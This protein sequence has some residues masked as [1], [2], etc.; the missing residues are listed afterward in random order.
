[1]AQDRFGRDISY[2]R[3]SLTDKC[4]L[5]CV[6]CMPEDMTFR[7]RQEL[8][9]D[10]EILRLVGVF[11]DLGFHKFRLTGGEPTVRADLVGLVRGIAQTPGVDTVAMT[12]NG[13]LLEQMAQPLAE[14]GLQR[15]N[16][17]IDTL[18]PRK[19]RQV[20]RWGDVQDV[21]AGI[22]AAERVGL[23]VKLNAVVVRGYNDREDVV[24]LARLTLFKPWQVRFI[25]M[26]PFG[27]VADFQQAGVVPEEELR[28]TIVA[29]LGPLT[30]VNAG[31]LD[32]EAR[33]Y[34]LAEGL[35]TLG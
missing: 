14:A 34:R 17:S 19:F 6:Y 32:G 21:W 7:P 24:D 13:V 28:A 11:A 5:R 23:R 18:D 35:G 4:N 9:Q 3:I 20:T 33:I 30:L 26:M 22:A 16:V 8:L 12:T 29:A 25:E 1:M 10:E 15:V 27:D 2:L 31:E